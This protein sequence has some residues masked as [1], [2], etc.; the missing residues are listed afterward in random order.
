MMVYVVNFF[1]FNDLGIFGSVTHAVFE[2]VDDANT[3]AK[4]LLKN[5]LEMD[6]RDIVESDLTNRC[7]GFSYG[8]WGTQVEAFPLRKG[9]S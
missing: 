3:Y 1:D 7:K 5:T 6:D 2:N 9:L 8:D 4:L